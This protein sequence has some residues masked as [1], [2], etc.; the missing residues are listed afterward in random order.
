GLSKPT[1]RAV[2]SSVVTIGKQVTIICEGPP[3]AMEYHF[4]KEGNPDFQI[5][6][7]HQDTEEKN[8]IFI[9]SIRSH[10]AGQYWCCYKSPAGT[11]EHSDTLELVV[12]GVYSSKVTLS[13]MSSH[14]V[15]S[16]GYVTLQ[17]SSQEEYNSFILMKEDQ[18][19]SMP[20]A[21]QNTYTGVFQAL[22]RV[23]PVTPNQ[24]WRFTCYGYYWNSSQPW[25]FPSNHV[26]LLVSVSQE[27]HLIFFYFVWTLHNST[28]WA[29]PVTLITSE[30]PITVWCDGT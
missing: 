18:I 14:V 3:N 22:F 16:G 19:F 24:R 26:E 1:L 11:S 25:S 20:M 29:E 21:S 17:C 4:Y 13:S 2:P 9:S 27:M 6:T 12:T 10:N 28:I 23:G 8:K 5:P 30:S 15:T 7:T